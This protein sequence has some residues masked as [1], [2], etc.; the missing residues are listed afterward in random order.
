MSN[1]S[2][3]PFFSPLGKFKRSLYRR[4]LMKQFGN[5]VDLF[6]EKFSK[7]NVL[8][9]YREWIRELNRTLPLALREVS[10]QNLRTHFEATKDDY[11]P[12]LILNELEA[13]RYALELWKKGDRHALKYGIPRQF[14][15]YRAIREQKPPDSNAYRRYT[16]F[17]YSL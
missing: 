1:G 16:P 10:K 15:V 3:T 12:Y 6:I 11:S 8:S 13:G 5:D 9:L 7:P 17:L 14:S 4:K 2:K